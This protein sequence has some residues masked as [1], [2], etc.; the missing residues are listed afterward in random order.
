MPATDEAVRAAVA[1]CAAADDK[2]A[3]DILVLEVADILNVVD[4]FVVA[5]AATDR[6]LRAVADEVERK[7]R[8]D[9]DRRPLR[10]E[11]EPASGWMLL[12]YGDIVCHLF[13]DE[14]RDYY[15]LER[16]W[17]DVPRRDPVT[18]ELYTA[19]VAEGSR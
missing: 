13:E 14:R 1:A 15:A 4:L 16:L 17:S 5:S 12:D 19:A 18:G 9:H 8:E 7:L 10:R 2:K 6:Q 3:S 11:G